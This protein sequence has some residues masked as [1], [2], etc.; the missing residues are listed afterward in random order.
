MKRLFIILGLCLLLSISVVFALFLNTDKKANHKYN[1]FNRT[2][3][4]EDFLQPVDTLNLKYASYYFSGKTDYS[5]YLG[6]YKAPGHLVIINNRNFNDTTH[7]SLRYEGLKQYRSPKLTID[8]PNFY[9]E[10]GVAQFIYK[11]SLLDGMATLLLDTLPFVRAYPISDQSIGLLAV[12][13]REN[14]LV[15]ITKG[16]PQLHLFRDILEEQGDGIFS[17]DGVMLYNAKQTTFVYVYFYRNQ[18]IYM[19]SSFNLI[20]R[21]NTIDTISQ[22]KIKVGEIL[23]ENSVSM[24]SPPLMV[25][26]GCSLSDEY[27]Y[28]NSNIL[29][30]NEEAEKFDRNSV[31]DVY[32]LSKGK[33]RFSFYIPPLYQKLRMKSFIVLRNEI[34][35]VLYRNLLIKYRIRKYLSDNDYDLNLLGE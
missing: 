15:K 11:G 22:A 26:I 25:N 19:D 34:L 31:I 18:Y 16:D 1:S 7:K 10:D 35:L 23:S 8:S 24:A 9:L 17:T 29:A 13:N 20:Y 4:D 33:Y 30:K 28:I 3:V 12:S 32:D 6:N 21:G 2:F 14:T 5:I 27:L